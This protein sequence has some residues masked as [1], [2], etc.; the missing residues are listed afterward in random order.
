VTI[1]DQ[2]DH[3]G[4]PYFVMEFLDGS[5]LTAVIGGTD[6]RSLERRVEIARQVCEALHFAHEHAVIHR[7]VKPANIM[8]IE[9]GGADQAKLVDFGIV[10]VE[11]SNSPV[12]RPSPQFYMSQAARN[13]RVDHRSDLFSLGIVL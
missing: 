10:H 13:D 5:D 9:R 1:H 4:R 6:T 3:N 11:D 8:V 2:G 12:R 7:D